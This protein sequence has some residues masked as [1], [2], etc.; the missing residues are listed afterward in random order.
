MSNRTPQQRG[1]V[2]HGA[3]SLKP[4][5]TPVDIRRNVH[6]AGRVGFW[7]RDGSNRP[8][9][10]SGKI[11]G[12]HKLDIQFPSSLF[13]AEPTAHGDPVVAGAR[14]PGAITAGRDALT[15]GIRDSR[16]GC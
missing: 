11:C 5:I 1:R 12:P 13:H 9:L 3:K 2:T 8:K 16:E 6:A 10:F 7:H 15:T 4:K 14:A